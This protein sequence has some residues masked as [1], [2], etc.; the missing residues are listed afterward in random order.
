MRTHGNVLDVQVVKEDQ[1]IRELVNHLFHVTETSN[2][3]VSMTHNTVEH[4]EHDNMDGQLDLTD[5]AAI[6]REEVFICFVLT[7]NVL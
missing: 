3:L 5:K 7:T 2:T 1:L 6:E 4:A